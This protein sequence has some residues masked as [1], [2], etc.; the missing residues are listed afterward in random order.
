MHRS[1]KISNKCSHR[2][3]KLTN[4]TGIEEYLGIG[5]LKQICRKFKDKVAK[6]LTPF[7]GKVAIEVGWG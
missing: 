1:I 6:K 2:S 3:F 4:S 5:E 7:K